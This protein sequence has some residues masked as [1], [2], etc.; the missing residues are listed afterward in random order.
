MVIPCRICAPRWKLLQPLTRICHTIPS[1]YRIA[2][3]IRRGTDAR[4]RDHEGA[5]V[6]VGNAEGLALGSVGNGIG[7]MVGIEVGGGISVGSGVGVVCA[8]TGSIP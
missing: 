6:V 3:Q 8:L 7:V 2:G 4:E 1:R 5:G